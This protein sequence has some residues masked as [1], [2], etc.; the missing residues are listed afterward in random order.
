MSRKRLHHDE[1]IAICEANI[2]LYLAQGKPDNARGW[3]TMWEQV[4]PENPKLEEWRL[5]LE[6]PNIPNLLR[7]YP[8]RGSPQ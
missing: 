8:E 4:D 2:H 6:I 1:L 3:L 7:G 5:R